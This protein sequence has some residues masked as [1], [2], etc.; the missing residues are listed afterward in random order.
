VVKVLCYKSEN[1]GFETDEV[2]V[3]FLIHLILPAPLGPGVYSTSNRNE[4]QRQKNNV[5]GE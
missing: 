2:N 5:S 3:R 1:C 4:Y